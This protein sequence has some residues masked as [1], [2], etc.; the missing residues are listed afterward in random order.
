MELAF[1][2]APLVVTVM[3]PT[4][5]QMAYD[6]GVTPVAVLAQL[7][8]FAIIAWVLVMLV[9]RLHGRG[10]WSMAGPV[11]PSLRNLKIAG[12][13]VFWLLLVQRFLPPWIAFA[14]LMETR[15]LIAWGIWII[16]T[17]AILIIQTGTEE[18]YFRGYLQQQ[19]AALSDNPLIWM[20]APSLLFGLGHYLNGYGPA[21]GVLY[22]LWATLLGLACADLTARTG[23]SARRWA[24]TCPITCSPLSSWVRLAGRPVVWRYSFIPP[25]TTANSITGCIR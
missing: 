24:C 23:T 16:P 20:G 1:V 25:P 8:T 18:L 3:L 10:F 21:D 4:G 12:V 17:I 22:A 7:A 13:G 2:V 6:A 14:E 15:N 19:C 9:R 11:G 5:L